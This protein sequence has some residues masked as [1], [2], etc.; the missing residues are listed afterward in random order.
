M[1]SMPPL[2]LANTYTVVA[3]FQNNGVPQDKWRSSM[4]IHATAQPLPTDLIISSLESFW[5]KNLRTDCSL[6]E[7]ELRNWSHGGPQPFSVRYPIWRHPVAVNGTKLA[8][9]GNQ[10][11]PCG[12]EVC[13]FVEKLIASGAKPGKMFLRGLLDLYELV[14]QAGGLWG[15]DM[16]RANVTPAHFLADTVTGIIDGFFGVGKDPGLTLVHVPNHGV[17]PAT[18]EPIVGMALVGPVTNKLTRKS[19]R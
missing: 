3:H 2:T 5:E 8:T 1:P 17:G 14:A 16:S 18:S 11:A 12:G 9:Y 4:E 13:G 10:G 15:I 7:T 19:R 6:V